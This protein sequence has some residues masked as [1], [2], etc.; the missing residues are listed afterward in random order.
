MGRQSLFFLFYQPELNW[1][2]FHQGRIYV[3]GFT[4]K[5]YRPFII[6]K[7]KKQTSYVFGNKN[8]S[9]NILSFIFVFALRMIEINCVYFRNILTDFVKIAL[10]QLTSRF[11]LGIQF[12]VIL[13]S[14]S[15]RWPHQSHRRTTARGERR[16]DPRRTAGLF[17]NA[18]FVLI[19]QKMPLLACVVIFFGNEYESC[20]P[21]IPNIS[22]HNRL[23]Q[24]FCKKKE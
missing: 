18:I 24:K 5:I 10:C 23:I 3:P 20:V 21:I 2:Q 17:S 16:V 4:Y 12:P 19:Q 11:V 14:Y 8:C 9:Q 13:T 1:A 7:K 22:I 15:N 6:L